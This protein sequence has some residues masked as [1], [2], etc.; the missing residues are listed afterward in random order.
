MGGAVVEW[1]KALLLCEKINE[2]HKDPKFAP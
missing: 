1:P 2:N